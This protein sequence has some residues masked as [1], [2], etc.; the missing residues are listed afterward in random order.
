M[1]R[2]I[3]CLAFTASTI[4][5]AEVINQRSIEVA[6][7]AS[8]I[9]RQVKVP[10]F[11]GREVIVTQILKPLAD[12]S[13]TY[14]HALQPRETQEFDRSFCTLQ[15][16]T[17]KSEGESILGSETLAGVFCEWSGDERPKVG[18]RANGVWLE[19][20]GPLEDGAESSSV[21]PNLAGQLIVLH[22]YAPKNFAVPLKQNYVYQGRTQVITNTAGQTAS[23]LQ[24]GDGCRVVNQNWVA[25]NTST[26]VGAAIN[27]YANRGPSINTAMTTCMLG[28]C[29]MDTGVVTVF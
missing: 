1:K 14:I 6:G 21:W 5:Q 16:G 3:V 27:C 29:A 9:E 12:G 2:F 15:G 26:T 17:L 18:I 20:L 8:F 22:A 10:D 4:T 25:A 19:P 24:I 13:L 28:R 23:Q 11:T 7:D